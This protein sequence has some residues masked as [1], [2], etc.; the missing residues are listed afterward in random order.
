MREMGKLMDET[1]KDKNLV[2]DLKKKNKEYLK[3]KMG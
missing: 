2:E 1:F 3:K